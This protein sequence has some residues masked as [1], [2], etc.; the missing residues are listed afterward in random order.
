MQADKPVRRL[1]VRERMEEIERKIE[2]YR[3]DHAERQQVEGDLACC[4]LFFKYFA[5]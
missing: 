3:K 4:I 2:L 5:G 1:S